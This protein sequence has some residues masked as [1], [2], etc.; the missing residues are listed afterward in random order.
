[1]KNQRKKLTHKFGRPLA[2]TKEMEEI[3]INLLS[4]GVSQ[5]KVA[6]YIGVNEKTIM[7]HK[8][9][10]P[11]FLE[12]LE[13]AKLETTRLAYKSLKIGMTKDW[14]AA[15]WWLERTEPA[16]FIE[17]K[18]LEIREMSSLKDGTIGKIENDP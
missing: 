3:I 12:R 14:R 17:K 13:K 5:K 18:E 2:I 7:T 11:D 6:R 15:A 1:M 10:F 16:R 4:D 8:M 9:N